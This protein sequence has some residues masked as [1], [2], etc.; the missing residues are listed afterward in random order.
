MKFLLFDHLWK[1]FLFNFQKKN[2]FALQFLDIGFDVIFRHQ[3]CP[4]I[5]LLFSRWCNSASYSINSTT[6]CLIPESGHISGIQFPWANRDQLSFGASCLRQSPHIA[7]LLRHRLSKKATFCLVVLCYAHLYK[8]NWIC[9]DLQDANLIMQHLE[10]YYCA[11]FLVFAHV[12]CRRNENLE[13][14]AYTDFMGD[15]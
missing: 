5:C 12:E 7:V 10:D 14:H 6:F 15:K 11:A 1:F 2:D 13:G 3:L 4:E 9:E 8:A